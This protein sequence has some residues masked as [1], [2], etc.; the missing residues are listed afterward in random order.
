MSF[1]DNKEKVLAVEL[2]QHGK[3]MLMKGEFK[4]SFYSF[5]D[6]GVIYDS[7]YTN[8]TESQSDIEG[9][10]L[11]TSISTY[12]I[13]NTDGIE[14]AFS[15]KSKIAAQ[16]ENDRT[17]L[18]S[19]Y[20]LGTSALTNQY[21]PA[22]DVNVLRGQ[23]TSSYAY[24][25]GSGTGSIW[26]VPIPQLTLATPDINLNVISGI[27]DIL[28]EKLNFGGLVQGIDYEVVNESTIVEVSDDYILI[29]ID[30]INSVFK[31][32]NFDIEVFTIERDTEKGV[33]GSN[34]ILTPLYFEKEE[35]EGDIWVEAPT[36]PEFD[37]FDHTDVKYY[38]D[39]ETDAEIDESILCKYTL[40]A[41]R[42]GIYGNRLTNCDEEE[43]ENIT[44]YETDNDEDGEDC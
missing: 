30:E 32:E 37:E 4:P 20:S 40:P 28:L 35:E 15:K 44:I 12:P 23:I 26:S 6:E 31:N 25:T 24:I 21:A 1:I 27:T 43:I 8:L 5:E 38:I 16:S 36:S 39:I 7:L 42:K 2:T 9:R 19:L 3:R 34:E 13:H 22:W 41:K 11:D 10:I 29:D 14:S 18:S 33:S 17:Y